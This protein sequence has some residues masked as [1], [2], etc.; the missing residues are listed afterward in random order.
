MYDGGYIHNV[1]LYGSQK[2]PKYNLSNIVAP[3]A[4]FYGK[5]DALVAP[6]VYIIFLYFIF[7]MYIKQFI[8]HI[9][10]FIFF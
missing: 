9:T 8:F 3:V 2:P 7:N 5:G 10:L 1:Q 6:Q 4:L